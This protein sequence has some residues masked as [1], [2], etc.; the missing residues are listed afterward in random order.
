MAGRLYDGPK[1]PTS[2]WVCPDCGNVNVNE[3]AQGCIVCAATAAAPPPKPQPVLK[4]DPVEEAAERMS[5]FMAP[6]E[7]NPYAAVVQDP[8]VLTVLIDDGPTGVRVVLTNDDTSVELRGN[9]L[10]ET[11]ARAWEAL[12]HPS[13]VRAFLTEIG[14]VCTKHQLM[15][16]AAADEYYLQVVPMTPENLQIL[17]D[18]RPA[19]V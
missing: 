12:H 1:L 7:G 3:V 15:V 5:A 14:E 2:S 9:D 8:E 6:L 10:G 4:A 16:T 11:F 19:E 17:L 18:A 13:P